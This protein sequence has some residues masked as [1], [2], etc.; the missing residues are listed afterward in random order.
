VDDGPS[1][2]SFARSLLVLF[3]VYFFGA[4]CFSL[5]QL[6]V[7]SCF[8]SFVFPLFF[9]VSLHLLRPSFFVNK[10]CGIKNFLRFVVSCF[11]GFFVCR[12]CCLLHF[13]YYAR[14]HTRIRT[15]TYITTTECVCDD[16]AAMLLLSFPFGSSYSH[17]CCIL[18]GCS[19]LSYVLV[20]VCWCR[21]F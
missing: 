21:Y 5:C 20:S 17:F 6:L 1:A 10:N 11:V 12:S 18:F 9:F 13:Y 15:H 14:T 4:N 16:A 7:S 2:L 3:V 8:S 19:V